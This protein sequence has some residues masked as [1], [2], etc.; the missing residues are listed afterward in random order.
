MVHTLSPKGS[1][2]PPKPPEGSVQEKCSFGGFLGPFWGPQVP[3]EYSYHVLLEST[4]V[5]IFPYEPYG[6]VYGE[7][8]YQHTTIILHMLMTTTLY[9][10]KGPKGRHPKRGGLGGRDPFLATWGLS[11]TPKK[12]LKVTLLAG[13]RGFWGSEGLPLIPRIL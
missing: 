10:P 12:G 8:V 3:R 1:P 6:R 4:Y 2:H 9:V 5:L 13:I 7:S 11:K